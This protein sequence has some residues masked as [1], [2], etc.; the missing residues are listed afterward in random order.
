[1]KNSTQNTSNLSND[2]INKPSGIF[3]S[4]AVKSFEEKLVSETNYLEKTGNK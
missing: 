2:F 1:M 4:V 3:T